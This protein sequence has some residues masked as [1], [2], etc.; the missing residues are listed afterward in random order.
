MGAAEAMF[1]DGQLHFTLGH[2]IAAFA[3]TKEGAR[4]V[5]DLLEQ[6]LSRES[7]ASYAVEDYAETAKHPRNSRK[8]KQGLIGFARFHYSGLRLT[9]SELQD[10][11]RAAGAW[12]ASSW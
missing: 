8:W 1:V 10:A 2:L 7:W 11:A 6:K 9:E 12:T 3:V 5:N 4:R